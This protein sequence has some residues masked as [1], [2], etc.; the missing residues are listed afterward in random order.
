MPLV[1]PTQVC[2]QCGLLVTPRIAPSP[3]R[4]CVHL[5]CPCGKV[6]LVL[7]SMLETVP[8]QPRI[9][10]EGGACE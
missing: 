2:V 3:V 6:K 1:A 7:A 4:G 10:G 8:D 9:E 5:E